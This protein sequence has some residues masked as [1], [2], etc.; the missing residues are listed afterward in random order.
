MQIPPHSPCLDQNS[1]RSDASNAVKSTDTSWCERQNWT[2]RFCCFLKELPGNRTEHLYL[3]KTESLSFVT[4]VSSRRSLGPSR[5]TACPSWASV[6]GAQSAVTPAHP[7]ECPSD[8]VEDGG[9]VG[10]GWH[11]LAQRCSLASLQAMTISSRR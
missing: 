5:G 7:C 3:N 8:A 1:E 9:A 2:L 11:W 10:I 6:R 4:S